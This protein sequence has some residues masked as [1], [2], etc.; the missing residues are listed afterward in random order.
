MTRTNYIALKEHFDRLIIG[1][2]YHSNGL[3]Q[4]R[5]VYRYA[6]GQKIHIYDVYQTSLRE[7]NNCINKI[8]SLVGP[9]NDD[10]K[11]GI[12]PCLDDIACVN[13]F[14]NDYFKGIT[15]E[16]IDDYVIDVY[17]AM[18]NVMIADPMYNVSDAIARANPYCAFIKLCPFYFTYHHILDTNPD[19]IG[20]CKS[21]RNILEKYICKNDEDIDKVLESICTRKFSSDFED[22]Y[23]TMTC[24]NT[25]ELF[26]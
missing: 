22:I 17:I 20:Y 5:D 18:T 16:N 6:F 23:S 26:W 21:F 8:I 2:H 24:N 9:A 25:V 13:I 12:I 11:T 4:I 10:I 7:R 19:I 3:E 1:S 15:T 14:N